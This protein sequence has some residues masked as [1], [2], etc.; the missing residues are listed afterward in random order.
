MYKKMLVPLDGSDFSECT[1][2]HAK[3]IA[4]G[5]HVPIVVLLRVMEP[6]HEV[7]ELD[8]SWKRDAEAKAKDDAKDYRA[9]IADSMVKEGLVAEPVILAGKP[10]EVILDY[11]AKNYVDL[12]IMSTHGRSGVSRWVFGSVTDRVLSHSAAP[13]LVVSPVGCRVSL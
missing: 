7:Y 1:L 6:L 2:E 8:E 5:C 12:I 4:V 10:D 13:V 9:K 11:I 3:A